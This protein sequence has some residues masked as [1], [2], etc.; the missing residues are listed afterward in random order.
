M[1]AKIHHRVS[2]DVRLPSP[3]ESSQ[4]QLGS[5]RSGNLYLF[6][7][8]PFSRT[9]RLMLLVFI[10]FSAKTGQN[11]ILRY[12]ITY[13]FPHDEWVQKYYYPTTTKRNELI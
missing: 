5:N 10:I 4:S 3:V 13:W 2:S 11:A 6:V 8:F 12:L 7:I 1:L 9:T